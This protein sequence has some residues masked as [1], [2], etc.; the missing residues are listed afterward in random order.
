MQ[1]ELI[2][3]DG[4]NYEIFRSWPL[5]AFVIDGDYS[6][7]ITIPETIFIDDDR[8]I[9]CTVDGIEEGAFR[10]CSGLTSITI[11][12]SVTYI[13][14]YTFEGCNALKSVT[15][16]ITDVF[17]TGLDAF[18]GIPTDATLYVPKGL[19]DT[20][21]ATADWN[22]FLNIVEMESSQGLADWESTNHEDYSIDSKTYEFSAEEGDIMSFD[23]YVSSEDNYDILTITL[24]GNTI[25]SSSGVNG[26]T[27]TTPLTAGSHT[28]IVTY[29]KDSSYSANNDNA[30]I[31]N[32]KITGNDV[33]EEYI[34]FADANVKAICVQN[35][36]KNHDG[37]LSYSEASAVSD[38]GTVFGWSEITSF[39]E[40]QY[41]TGLTSIGEYAFGGCSSLT[42]VTIPNGLTSIGDNAF[43]YC[44]ALTSV[45]IPNNV[46]SIGGGAFS[47][48]S[49]LT[50]ITIPNSVTSIGDW[51]FSGCS[52]LTSV[53]IP[54]SVTS[55]E[56]YTFRNCSGLI[57]IE[58]PGSVTS[59][60]NNAFEGCSVL[61]YVEIPNS[62]T[63]IGYMAFMDCSSL[64]SIEIPNSVTSIGNTAFYRCSSLTSI[65]IPN[66]VT[67]VESYTFYDCI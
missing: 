9:E 62:V 67:S 17:E 24:D 4:I 66:S 56:A 5:S 37:E 42:S 30:G 61:T 29:S 2:N 60:G 22:R 55:I 33:P 36:D 27:Y 31:R 34:E 40:L 54:N 1:R 65:V 11:P 20:Y 59:I 46:S 57:S 8:Y 18:D 21:R 19:V 32:I 12:N 26:E 50:F 41:F 44:S 38:I 49:S 64:T 52:S 25:V 51:A 15:S 58:I 10:G 53:T 35:W 3:V 43:A 28:L 23:W 63:T 39:D 13:G 16:Y 7:D 48:C 47:G 14:G 45:I 6:G